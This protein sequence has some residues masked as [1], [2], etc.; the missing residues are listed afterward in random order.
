[1]IPG[2]YVPSGHL[3]LMFKQDGDDSG[4]EAFVPSGLH[5]TSIK[6][7]SSSENVNIE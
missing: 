3:D 7:S 6:I 5:L 1:M 2:H 4:N